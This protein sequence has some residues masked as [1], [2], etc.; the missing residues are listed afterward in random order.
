M[1]VLCVDTETSIYNKGNPFDGRN[2]LVCYSWAD[3]SGSGANQATPDSLKDLEERI[4]R[5]RIF[6]GFNC[7]FDLHWLRKVGIR[8]PD[9]VRIFDC[10]LAEFLI[11]RQSWKYPDLDASTKRYGLTSKNGQRINDYWNSGIQTEDIPWEELREYAVNDAEITLALY[12]RQQK[13]MSPSQIRLARLQMM[14]LL[15]LQEMEW[16][17]LKYNEELCTERAEEIKT[18]ISH[19]EEQLSGVYP[20][21]PISFSSGDDLSAFLYG[22]T[23][24]EIRKKHIGFFKT[25]AKVGQPRY[26]NEEVFH[27]LPRLVE[28][29]RGSELKKKGFYATNK[30]TLLKLRPTRKTKHLI[31]LIQ[32]QVRYETLLSKTYNGIVKANRDQNWEPG[33]L[34]GQYN[35]ITVSTGRLSSS[36]PNL[37]NLDSAAL[38]L[39]IT[40]FNDNTTSTT[41]TSPE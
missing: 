29:L 1:S 12:L 32:Q 10:Q 3:E 23:I 30:E 22:G 36:A 2:K 7:K 25:G 9:H 4:N 24:V 18:K 6:V 11:S 39:F 33:W 16:N 13:E 31:E 38:D 8:I 28:P 40:R 20:D 21:V 26:S 27:E 41:T 14:D 15:I 5:C 19:I 35:Q 37:Q 17:G 34:H